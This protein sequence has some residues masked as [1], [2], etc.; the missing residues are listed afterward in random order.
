MV[1]TFAVGDSDISDE[2]L[3]VSVV[4]A[5]VAVASL[6]KIEEEEKL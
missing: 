4:C 5:A 1:G 2:V 6:F 3:R